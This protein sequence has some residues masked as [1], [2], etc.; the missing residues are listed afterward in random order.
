MR[1]LL[2]VF[3]ILLA[4]A[5]FMSKSDDSAVSDKMA[6]LHRILP[7]SICESLKNR[8]VLLYKR[9]HCGYLWSLISRADSAYEVFYGCVYYDGHRDFAPFDSLKLLSRNAS[10][11]DWGLYSLP[12]EAQTMTPLKR[13]VYDPI[14]TSLTVYSSGGETVFSSRNTETYAGA[15]SVI[16]NRRYGRLDLLMMWLSF[17][18]IRQYIT[19]L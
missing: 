15:D 8:H 10:V 3:M 9:G 12:G 2:V 7:D 16:F 11:I 6:A 17:P 18:Y 13:R 1:H 14:S 19:D 5:A 4:S